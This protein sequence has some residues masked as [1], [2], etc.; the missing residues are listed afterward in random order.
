M[1]NG[2]MDGQGCPKSRRL[3]IN[4]PT[5]ALETLQTPPASL[6]VCPPQGEPGVMPAPAVPLKESEVPPV[7]WADVEIPITNEVTLSPAASMSLLL[8]DFTPELTATDVNTPMVTSILEEASPQPKSPP[9]RSGK[10]LSWLRQQ[11]A[12]AASYSEDDDTSDTSDS[13]KEL[14]TK[15]KSMMMKII[16][17]HGLTKVTE[18]ITKTHFRGDLKVSET[19]T[20][21]VYERKPEE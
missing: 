2:G 12:V 16:I 3:I 21:R 10:P 15:F 11:Q 7:L 5:T 1:S 8:P 6:G 19:R 4:V 17:E 20:T 9:Q 14:T 18:S 13:E